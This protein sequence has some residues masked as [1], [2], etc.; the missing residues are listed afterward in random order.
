MVTRVG[1]K[2]HG[3]LSAIAISSFKTCCDNLEIP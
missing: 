1:Q 2:K 3:Q